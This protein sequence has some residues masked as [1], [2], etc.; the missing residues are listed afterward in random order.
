MTV[1]GFRRVRA[2]LITACVAL[3]AS[4]VAT[5]Q[6]V[7]LTPS[8]DNTL[9]EDV[10]GG[11]SNGAGL[12]FFSGNTNTP[13]I[14]R[15]LVA[16]DIA[17]NIPAR[18]TITSVTLTLHMSKSQP[19]SHTVA[20]HRVTADWGEGTSIAAGD[21]GAGAPATTG[22]ATWV[23]RF[24]NTTTWTNVGGNFSATASAS[25]TVAD[26]GTYTWGSTAAMVSDVQQWLDT[27]STNFGWLLKGNESAPGTAK[28]FDTRENTVPSI[29]PRLTIT[30]TPPTG[31]EENH[32]STFALH[33]NYPNP[34]NPS[35]TIRFGLATT[36]H[37]RLRIFN[38]L[39]QEVATL[40]NATLSAGEHA[41]QWNAPE[42]SS[43][44]YVYRLEAGGAVAAR[45]LVLAR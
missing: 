41:V 35:T 14:R 10:T 16:F 27:A 18:S 1:R 28:R 11:L 7:T 12:H 34:F 30:Y 19:G 6:T 43:G 25:Q 24:F 39:G 40:V 38:L 9:Y 32:P 36:S 17:G 2:V 33:Q 22:D 31:V 3:A 42:F 26:T 15:A 5:A 20:L 45:K 23:H 29:R 8:K 44:V 37:A 21:E 13:K 4:W